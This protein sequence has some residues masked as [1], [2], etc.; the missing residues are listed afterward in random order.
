MA[1]RLSAGRDRLIAGA[2]RI[3]VP[4]SDPAAGRRQDRGASG[5]RGQGDPCIL[6]A[7]E[8]E[9]MLWVVA[10]GASG[11]QGFEDIKTLLTPS[12]A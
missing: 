8:S 4:E 7:M 2:A 12:V 1:T 5:W 11:G 3:L 9:Q 10:I 6:S